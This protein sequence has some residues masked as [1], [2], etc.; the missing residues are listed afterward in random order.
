MKQAYVTTTPKRLYPTLRHWTVQEKLQLV[1]LS[2]L[3]ELEKEGFVNEM[4]WR[5]S[6]RAWSTPLRY[7]T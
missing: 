2:F 6:T 4:A 1:D 7:G 3:Q 5:R